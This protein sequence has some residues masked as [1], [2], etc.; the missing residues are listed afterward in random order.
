MRRP[1]FPSPEAGDSPTATDVM[2]AASEFLAASEIELF[3]LGMW[4]TWGG[5]SAAQAPAPKGDSNDSA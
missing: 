5:V 2:V 4:Q 3:E 1:P